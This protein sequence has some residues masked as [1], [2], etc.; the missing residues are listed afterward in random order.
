[1][2]DSCVITRAG[3]PVFDQNTGDETPSSTVV[4][5]GKCQLR[6]PSVAEVDREFGHQQVTV[7]AQILAV[8][9]GVSGIQTEDVAVVTSDDPQVDGMRFRITGVPASTWAVC[10]NW[11]V[12]ALV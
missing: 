5:S 2:V 6:D 9:F 4:Y 10:N 7:A 1:M 11:Q 12:E 8:P 3:A